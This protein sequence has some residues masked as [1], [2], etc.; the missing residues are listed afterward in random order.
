MRSF[1]PVHEAFQACCDADPTYSAQL[2][3]HVAGERVIDLT[4]GP[5]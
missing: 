1:E 3:V 4:G 2:T 5:R